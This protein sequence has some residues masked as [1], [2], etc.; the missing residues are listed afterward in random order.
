MR[1]IKFENILKVN[2]EIKEKVRRWR[3]KEEIRK[4]MINQHIINKEEHSIWLE[5][6][7][8]KNDWKFWIVFVDNIPVGSVYLQN[9]D[10]KK[11]TSEWGFYIGEDAYKG[12]GLGKCILF[13]FLKRFFEE[14]NFNILFTKVIYNNIAALNI[15][16]KFR[17]K[18]INDYFDKQRKVMLLKFTKKDWLKWKEM[19]KNEYFHNSKK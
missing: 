2:D 1:E 11:L 14:M 5:S 19:L 8:H 4:Y 18:I 16:R 17:F 13:E 12:K 9:I 6:L 10:Y 3:N 15:Y 7:K